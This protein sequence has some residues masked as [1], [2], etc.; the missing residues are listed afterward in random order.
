ML[1]EGDVDRDLTRIH[2][3][4]QKSYSK[5]MVRVATNGGLAAEALTTSLRLHCKQMGRLEDW[6]LDFRCWK[7]SWIPK[8]HWCRAELDTCR[9]IVA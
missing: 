8:P 6:M 9:R 1:S 7:I 3:K 4:I 5:W 2:E